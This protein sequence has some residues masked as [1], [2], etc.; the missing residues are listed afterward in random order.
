MVSRTHE[1]LAR[2]YVR[3]PRQ[4]VQQ[5]NNNPH[6]S[7]RYEGDPPETYTRNR[8]AFEEGTARSSNVT[9]R[10]LPSGS[11]NFSNGGNAD[12]VGV[13]NDNG[14]NAEAI[15]YNP[16][17]SNVTNITFRGQS[18]EHNTRNRDYNQHSHP[19]PH[20]ASASQSQYHRQSANTDAPTNDR[21][22]PDDGRDE[23][24]DQG[25]VPSSDRGQH[26]SIGT[27]HASGTHQSTPTNPQ[28][29][30]DNNNH[31]HDRKPSVILSPR[32]SRKLLLKYT[33]EQR[34]WLRGVIGDITMGSEKLEEDEAHQLGV[35]VDGID[36]LMTVHFRWRQDIIAKGDGTRSSSRYHGP[37]TSDA[38]AHREWK[39]LRKL[40]PEAFSE[41][42]NHLCSD[43]QLF[44]V[45]LCPQDALNLKYKQVGLC[46]AGTGE[47]WYG[48]MGQT[49]LKILEVVLPQTHEGIR[50]QQQLVSNTSR[51]G[52]N[53]LWNIGLL[54]VQV[55]DTSL[56]LARPVWDDEDDL[57][58]WL[59]KV[60]THRKL[61]RHRNQPIS[62]K[63]E[64][65][66]FLRG[67]TAPRYAH[68][69]NN[70][71]FELN[72]VPLTTPYAGAPVD[73]WQLPEKWE[74]NLLCA[75]IALQC[76]DMDNVQNAIQRDYTSTQRSQRRVN[77]LDIRGTSTL[78][79][80]H[81]HGF[82]A[83][84]N[85]L[86]GEGKTFQRRPRNHGR[87]APN[88][89]STEQRRR[90]RPT[91]D[92]ACPC[93]F[94]WGHLPPHCD[95]LAQFVHSKKYLRTAPREVVEENERNWLER[96]KKWLGG[97]RAD[98]TPRTVA[99]T[100]ASTLGF[101]EDDEDRFCELVDAE[102]DWDYFEEQV[103]DEPIDDE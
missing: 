92:G 69:A 87:P 57:F 86:R 91:F 15:P 81:L 4:Q 54:V 31:H 2:N 40:T 10:D 52:F 20:I 64:L 77:L 103:G 85:A 13:S 70:L 93:C 61:L 26:Q 65:T 8:C 46:A 97:E 6:R 62:A 9:G 48:E 78:E 101:G 100:Y 28:Y 37:R 79:G 72:N 56:Q 24:S 23:T 32:P 59:L 14:D 5:V 45:F 94:R 95:F 44:G 12:N 63:D 89:R 42:Y 27:N 18:R 83:L 25:H 49:L 21:G 36:E 17:F 47:Y 99:M 51:N 38:L 30:Q 7:P 33:S 1:W 96:N 41:F 29:S 67:I 11:N 16:R 90:A 74:I 68:L 60:T 76:G 98:K 73:E 34:E 19:H 66:I 102:I 82:E 39:H 80:I 75:N 71:C 50:I 58:S 55:W 53:L 35:N 22:C 84:V 43:C 3:S 88:P